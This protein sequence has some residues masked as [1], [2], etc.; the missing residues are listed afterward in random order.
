MRVDELAKI[1][2]AFKSAVLDRLKSIDD[3]IQSLKEGNEKIEARLKWVEDKL[4]KLEDQSRRENL[5]FFGHKE[6][7]D[8]KWEETEKKISKFVKEKLEIE[9]EILF[10]RV[11]RL[12]RPRQGVNSRP[13]K[14]KFLLFK[15]KDSVLRNA[16]KL[17]T[18]LSVFRK[19]SARLPAKNERCCF[20]I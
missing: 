2:E 12:G 10:H 15:D 13:I 17:R 14:V 20:L 9:G 4:S 7:K 11:H 16:Y 5:L 8:E 19:T 3:N 6:S 18:P 1:V